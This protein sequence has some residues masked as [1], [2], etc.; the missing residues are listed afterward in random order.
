MSDDLRAQFEAYFSNS[1]RGRIGKKIPAFQRLPD[2][3]YAD[4]STQRHWWT[5]QNAAL[6]AAQPPAAAMPRWQLVPVEPTPEMVC[7]MAKAWQHAVDIG[8]DNECIAEWKAAI[9]AAPAAQ[10]VP[11]TGA[12]PPTPGWIGIG[13]EGAVV[14]RSCGRPPDSQRGA[15]PAEPTGGKS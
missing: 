11:A 14:C 7:A 15:S 8:D 9:A 2:G 4:D 5:W 6:A 12:Q 3:T 10:P 1:R 13:P